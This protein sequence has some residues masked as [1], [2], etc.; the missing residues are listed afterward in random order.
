MIAIDGNTVRFALRH[1]YVELTFD[2]REV[3]ERLLQGGSQSERAAK[4]HAFFDDG[5]YGI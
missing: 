4:T 5:I 1:G 2:S 3:M